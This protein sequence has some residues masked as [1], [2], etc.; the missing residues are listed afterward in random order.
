VEQ[1]IVSKV[2]ICFCSFSATKT[3]GLKP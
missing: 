3:S 1:A 2:V